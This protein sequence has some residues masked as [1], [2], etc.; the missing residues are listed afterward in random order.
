MVSEI[1]NL[2]LLD[3]KI[4]IRA[5]QKLFD[6]KKKKYNDSVIKLTRDLRDVSAWTKDEI[7]AR[8]SW[9]AECFDII[10][11]VDAPTSQIVSFP[12]WLAARN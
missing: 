9:L 12:R 11:S 7:K 1:G 3:S 8:T 5:Q 10:W 2:T 6:E 4:N